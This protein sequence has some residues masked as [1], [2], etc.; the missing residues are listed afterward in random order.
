MSDLHYD[1]IWMAE[2]A[3]WILAVGFALWRGDRSARLMAVIYLAGFGAMMALFPNRPA[4]LAVDVV[5][6]LA[7]CAV[8][9]AARTPRPWLLWACIFQL[10]S[11]AT[12]TAAM[13]DDTIG[14]LAYATALNTWWMLQVA[15]LFWGVVEVEKR[16][17]A[18]RAAGA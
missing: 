7:M 3:A 6:L 15:A 4:E 1:I 13:L 12:R 18:E 11:A 2:Y 17:R 16:R 8:A 14:K 10:I 9:L 5:G